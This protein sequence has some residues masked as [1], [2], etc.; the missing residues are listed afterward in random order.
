M[1]DWLASFL[2]QKNSVP[3]IVNPSNP[4]VGMGRLVTLNQPLTLQNAIDQVKKHI[5]LPH[6]RVGVGKNCQLNSQINTVAICAGSGA[7]VF[8]TTRADLYLTGE[9]SHHE[10]LE[11]TQSG[12][13]VILC[14]HSDSERGFLK[15]FAKK[16]QCDG[17]E[18]SVSKCDRDC[19]T[20]I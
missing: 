8:G 10:V 7:S 5:G 20:I 13:N 19:L 12:I 2:S 9:M 14:N 18:F 6:L 3:L 15:E 11:A 17:V 16:F 4:D 1:N